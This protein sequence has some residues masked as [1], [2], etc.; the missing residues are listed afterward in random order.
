MR[1][2]WQVALR[3]IAGLW[4]VS[5]TQAILLGF[6]GQGGFVKVP[7]DQLGR[8]EALPAAPLVLTAYAFVWGALLVYVY[9]LWRRV[10]RVERDLAHVT[11]SLR[12]RGP[13]RR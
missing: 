6:Q 2:M 9:F 7:D 12:E 3:M 11:Q 1:T 10:G 5:V 8:Q 13:A 4:V